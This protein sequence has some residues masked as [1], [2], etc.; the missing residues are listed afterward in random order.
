M[1][2]EK[3][4]EKAE[5]IPSGAKRKLSDST[6]ST[7]ENDDD[8]YVKKIT[9]ED[10]FW[11]SEDDDI[12]EEDEDDDDNDNDNDEEESKENEE[13]DLCPICLGEFEDQMIGIPESCKHTFCADC[14][15][16]W[17]KN[18][19]NCPVDRKKFNMIS[20]HLT[21]DGPVIKQIPVQ[22]KTITMVFEEPPT[23]CEICHECDREEVLLLCDDC[24][25]GYHADCLNPPLSS[26]PEE[27]WFCPRCSPPNDQPSTSGAGRRTRSSS[28]VE[29]VEDTSS[30]REESDDAMARR[31]MFGQLRR[32]R[33]AART[34]A[35]NNR[36]RSESVN[37]TTNTRGRSTRGRGA[38]T[39]AFSLRKKKR[40]SKKRNSAS[41]KKKNKK[42]TKLELAR[43]KKAIQKE[44]E[45]FREKKQKKKKNEVK[46]VTKKLAVHGHSFDLDDF[47]DPDD[48]NFCYDDQIEDKTPRS[49]LC[50][51]TDV[52]GN[53]LGGFGTL[54]PENVTVL[55]DGTLKVNEK[56]KASANEKQSKVKKDKPEETCIV[57]EPKRRTSSTSSTEM[58]E[59]VKKNK[60][61][62]KIRFLD[63]ADEG[64]NISDNEVFDD[65]SLDEKVPNA[66]KKGYLEAMKK[67]KKEEELKKQIEEM[68]KFSTNLDDVNHQASS[69]TVTKFKIPK[70]PK[71]E[72]SDVIETKHKALS[73]SPK[74]PQNQTAGRKV[75][76]ENESPKPLTM[77]PKFSPKNTKMIPKSIK[78]NGSI[79]EG[80]K[81]TDMILSIISN[82]K[83]TMQQISNKTTRK[84]SGIK[85]TASDQS[86]RLANIV[87]ERRQHVPEI[88]KKVLSLEEKVSLHH[89]GKL[90]IKSPARRRSS[91]I[92]P[93]QPESFKLSMIQNNQLRS[94]IKVRAVPSCSSHQNSLAP[95]NNSKSP[96]KPIS[97]K[98]YQE[99]KFIDDLFGE[100][101]DEGTKTKKSVTFREDVHSTALTS[102]ENAKERDN[103]FGKLTLKPQ[104]TKSLPKFTFSST[105]SKAEPP[106]VT[107]PWSKKLAE[108][109]RTRPVGIVSPQQRVQPEDSS[110]NKDLCSSSTQGKKEHQSESNSETDTQTKERH[111]Q[112]SRR[113]AP[114]KIKDPSSHP[115]SEEHIQQVK[116]FMK[117]LFKSNKVNKEQ[118]KSILRE[119]VRKMKR[120]PSR[121]TNK[122][123]FN[124]MM[125]DLVRDTLA[126]HP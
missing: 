79:T 26:I 125:K 96:K 68:K 63:E 23:Y 43:E 6:E 58:K 83:Q 64:N 104:S 116:D 113:P 31:L 52:I 47:Y 16:E 32:P 106:P 54:N 73:D 121:Y 74:K 2:D 25:N 112:P 91:D 33:T 90:K 118:W 42:K 80:S 27:E 86:E 62:R 92:D 17:T 56:S 19:N 108:N 1:E 82:A 103:P 39:S 126:S 109:A 29:S 35:S 97:L 37:R 24:D 84:Q 41:P 94:I 114:G 21:K 9:Q 99:R 88:R 101:N 102:K 30:T 115:S 123:A 66:L 44:L 117:P 87:Q 48:E 28:A 18:V 95:S 100:T 22:D 111:Q 72:E 49:T 14:I 61:R 65:P 46:E 93:N 5:L 13:N 81:K 71:S 105:T 12:D 119:A 34:V 4:N 77:N 60:K 20:V 98:D 38:S 55:K 8:N 89:A 45:R 3:K 59:I 110:K 107:N 120:H 40:I 67:K 36:Q 10:E 70:K 53:I 11:E 85:E 76:L 75:K 124:A 57:I 78:L 15:E 50:D 7:E 51:T 122:E 69:F